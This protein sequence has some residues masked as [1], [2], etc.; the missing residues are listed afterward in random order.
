MSR[1]LKRLCALICT[2]VLMLTM[3]FSAYGVFLEGADIHSLSE[4]SFERVSIYLNGK[5]VGFAL[6]PGNTSYVSAQDFCRI[7]LG[8]SCTLYWDSD[9]TNL[10]ISSGDTLISLN[11]SEHYITANE[12]CIPLGGTVYNVDGDIYVPIRPLAQ[13]FAA[14]ISWRNDDG[15]L[16]I[17]ISHS[18]GSFITHGSEFYNAEDLYWLSRVIYAESGNQPMDGMIG[19]GNVVLNRVR[20]ESGAF[21]DTVQGVIFQ[22]GQF[23]VVDA[24]TIYSEP[25]PRCVLA[26]K[27]CLEGANTVGDSLF[28]LNPGISN[29]AWFDTYRIFRLSIGEHYFYA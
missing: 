14:D 10:D 28:F 25:R 9:E 2:A 23:S 24:G 16:S 7:M 1:K 12:R 22:P 21:P 26:A 6:K 20:D 4:D 5:Y 27:L 8:R 15:K 3:C 13:V 19:V 17:H 18:P 29:S 11:L